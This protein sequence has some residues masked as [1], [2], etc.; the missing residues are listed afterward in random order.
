MKIIKVNL[1][2]EKNK[3]MKD[4]TILP[5]ADVHIGD[6]L[7]NLK[8]FKEALERIKKEPNTYTII[9][10]D[11]CNMALKNSKSDV[12]SDSL[13]PMQ[14]VITVV[15]YLKPIKNKILV[16][17]TGNHE[18]R[19]MKETNIDVTRLIARELGLEDR[20]ANG[21]WYL[22]LTFGQ[23]VK[24]RPV[25]YGI[26]GIHGY[27][28]GRKS[29]GKI[30]RLEDMTQV[31]IAD[32]YLMSHT[33]KPIATKN[34]IYIPYYQSK[35]LSKQEMYYLMTNSFLE[36]DGGYA[37]KMGFPPASTSLTEAQLC[38]TKRKIKILI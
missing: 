29:G 25:T 11:L 21:W 5:I 35:A 22:Y 17:G 27:G 28:G 20:Y 14:Q 24:K 10:G 13:S 7:S 19:T 1:N 32:L 30:N 31:V 23:D 36:S 8:L 15:D 6:K 16:I 9:N 2:E 12:Y 34:C 38:S 4:I 18:D 3:I 26:T 33:H 37:E